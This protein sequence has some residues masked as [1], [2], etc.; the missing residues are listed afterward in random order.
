M[1]RKYTAFTLIELLV[2]ISIIALLIGILLPAL[3]KARQ[4]ARA[5]QCKSNMKQVGIWGTIYATENQGILPHNKEGFD[6]TGSPPSPLLANND[7]FHDVDF[8]KSA[9]EWGGAA[10]DMAT[11]YYSHVSTGTKRVL[12]PSALH[13][14]ELVYLRADRFHAFFGDRPQPFRGVGADTDFSLNRWLGGR[15][16]ESPN[17]RRA[18][19]DV[20]LKSDVFWF[21]EAADTMA[22]ADPRVSI[23]RWSGI[24][25]NRNFAERPMWWSSSGMASKLGNADGHGGTAAN[26][27][28]GDGHVATL[29]D[30]EFNAMN[31]PQIESWNGKANP[32][33]K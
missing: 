6:G 20:W 9:G 32:L 30:A 22:L 26:F 19:Q 4:V 17:N 2:V 33:R 18:P 7:W 28:Y 31:Q 29:T 15:G 12:Q 16:Q 1:S 21:S 13:C 27:L 3:T 25:F 14:P 5:S 8:R 23:N 10:P 11:D 24:D